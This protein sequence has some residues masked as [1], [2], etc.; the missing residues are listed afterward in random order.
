M[1]AFKEEID[2]LAKKSTTWII[3]SN[4]LGMGVHADSDSGRRFTDLQGWANQ[5]VAQKA[6]KATFMVSGLPLTVK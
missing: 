2:Q 4:E 6:E 5:Y 3:I 1:Q